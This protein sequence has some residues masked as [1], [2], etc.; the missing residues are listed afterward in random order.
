MSIQVDSI[1]TYIGFALLASGVFMILA[2]FDII[3]V[4]QVTV[5]KGRRTW[6]VGFIF[7]AAGFVMLFPEF[8]SSNRVANP[9]S[10]IESTPAIPPTMTAASSSDTM[11]EWLP[12]DF[13]NA[14]SSLWQDTVGGTYTAIG[15]KNA[16][17]WS[18]EQYEGNLMLSFDINSSADQASGCVIIYGDGN[19]FTHGSLIFC[20][21]WD[22]YGLEKHTIYHEGENY[23]EFTHSEVNLNKK[24][25]SIIIEIKDEIAS[26]QV[27]DEQVIF[28]F[29]DPEEI[30]RS[31]RIGLLKKW[32][33]PTVTFS[34]VRIKKS[35]N[36][37]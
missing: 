5:K 8:T 12:I 36:G 15:S 19:G 25:Y 30:N 1:T 3:S 4:Q 6:V 23:L 29:F 34:N 11:S 27:N 33:D 10:A 13:V 24:V 28:S 20:V 18:K 31:G 2:G 7:A 32:F 22:G 14:D 17:A 16:F 21:D 37:R 35:G 9:N 26:M